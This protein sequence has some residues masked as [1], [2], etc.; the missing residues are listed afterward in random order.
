MQK[1]GL[2][3]EAKRLTSEYATKYQ[4]HTS[5]AVV[6]N[7]LKDESEVNYCFYTNTNLTSKIIIDELNIEDLIQKLKTLVT[8][9]QDE[10]HT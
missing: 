2:I 9:E 4:C 1:I 10:C 8:Q 7:C 6:Y 3:E 5:F